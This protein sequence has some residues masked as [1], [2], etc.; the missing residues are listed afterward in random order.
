MARVAGIDTVGPLWVAAV[1]DGG[2]TSW[3]VGDTAAVLA[4]A[5]TC[6]MVAIDIPIGFVAT[7]PRAS[8]IEARAILGAQGR[9]IFPT[10]PAAAMAVGRREGTTR[11][12]R[13]LA[14][15]ESRRAGGAGISTQSWGIAGKILDVEDELHRLPWTAATRVVETHPE[16]A[17]R[18]MS[19]RPPTEIWPGKKTA[20]GVARRLAALAVDPAV[21]DD[22][23]LA[24]VPIDDALDA[25]AAAWTA[26]RILRDEALVLGG[27]D[28]HHAVW[29][30][31]GRA[32]GRAVIWV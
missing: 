23:V 26:A 29:S 17:F 10:P 21:L 19:T 27:R 9:S 14:Q 30:G 4:L 24:Q 8:E 3:R 6:D 5:E 12:S 22:P 2:A 32:P 20:A 31:G 18:V 15:E 16:T 7:G 28:A 1:R 25:L 11:A 13:E